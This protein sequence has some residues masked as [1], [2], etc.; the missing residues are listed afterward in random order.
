VTATTARSQQAG[1]TRSSWAG[2]VLSWRRGAEAVRGDQLVTAAV[3]VGT[4]VIGACFALFERGTVAAAWVGVVTLSITP[5][6]AFVCWQL[7]RDRLTR[8][9]AVLGASLT[10][11]TLVTTV[12]AWLQ[13]TNLGVL[14][15]AT[16]GVGGLGSAA[17]LLDQLARHTTRPPV[18]PIGG[19][20][21]PQTRASG[22]IHPDHRFDRGPDGGFGSGP[23]RGF[24]PEPNRRFGQ[25]PDRGFGPGPQGPGPGQ[26][27]G[28]GP[29]PQGFRP[30]QERRFD[31]GPDW[32]YGLGPDRGFDQ[33]PERRFDR[34][35]VGGFGSG[36]DRGFG[37][38][39]QGP[40]PGQERGFGPGPQGL[41]P[42]QERRFDRGPVGGLGPDP[43]RRVDATSRGSQAHEAAR[44]SYSLLAFLLVAL[45]VAAGLWISTVIHAH[46]RAMGVYGLLPLLGVPFAVAVAVT[47][48][49]LAVAFRSIRTAWP[50]AVAA[51][52]LLLVELNGTPM[53]LA[54]TPLGNLS[55]YEHFGVI[56]Y[57]FHGGALNDPLDVYQQ[58]PGFFAAAAGLERLTGESPFGNSNW[59]QLF[60]EALNALIL[61]GIAR[62]FSRGRQ[63][64]PYVTVLLFETV[65]WEGQFYFAPQTM[66]FTMTLF[67][68]FFLLPLLETGKLRRL[69]AGRDWLRVPR[70][71]IP[72]EKRANNINAIP[73]AVGLISVFAAITVM[74]QLTPYFVFVSVAGLWVLGVFRHPRVVI[75]LAII[76]FG[77]PLLH[78][79]AL[80]HNQWFTG[81]SLSG[82]TNAY[83][84]SS[85]QGVQ[86]A[87]K[88]AELIGSAFWLITGICALSYRRRI[89]I[90]AIPIILAAAPFSLVL[91][92]SYGGEAVNRVFLF[93]SPWCALIIAMRLGDLARAPM[94][95]WASV[96]AWALLAGLGS[97]QAGDFGLFP[98]EQITPREI[99]ASAYFLDH[100][101]QNSMLVLAVPDFPARVN[102]RYVLH[103]T[104]QTV[105]DPLAGEVDN[106]HAPEGQ[107][108]ASISPPTCRYTTNPQALAI[109][110][111]T[112]A[113]GSAYLVI[114]PSMYRY[115]DYSGDLAPGSLSALIPRLEASAYWKVWYDNNGVIIFQAIPQGKPEPAVKRKE[116]GQ[117]SASR[118]K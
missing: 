95:R 63:V 25:G 19:G 92:N 45:T 23:D 91:V 78:Y 109:S 8:L 48:G 62:R 59:A 82:T 72:K 76:L 22:W 10:W 21:Y 57:I 115:V 110:V 15:A 81:F 118:T 70:L 24:W 68:L 28:F 80:S 2:F 111:T 61:F 41:G 103:D 106:C 44:L 112:L 85:G 86:L 51:L 56:D 84:A 89:G 104:T 36:P 53:F 54:V 77:Y 83:P 46:G 66:A 55:T 31:R 88:L 114:S 100:A 27:R 58:W 96:G 9:I 5:G 26:E 64:V 6:C 102:G 32:S 18:I 50:A 11:T 60:F 67:F 16:A 47:I 43:V 38:G 71:D 33:G 13:V 107:A 65:T 90:I 4:A 87:S 35:P 14:V 20:E 99:Q 17:F 93:S 116:K 49:V 7:T 12:L 79:G 101:P 3:G 37:P 117:H 97:A 113:Q 40:G 34:G 42:G 105:N 30:G 1:N 69:F 74:H 29:G 98:T 108:I 52:G 39:P 75:A 73:L 94:L